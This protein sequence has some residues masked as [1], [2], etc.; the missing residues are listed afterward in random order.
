MAGGINLYAYVGQ[1]PINLIDP[2]G[3]KYAEQYATA[4]AIAGTGIVAAGSVVVDV[5][6][7][8]LNILATPAELAGGA[9]LGGAIGY[10][11]GSVVDWWMGEDS[12]DSCSS[13]GFEST[14]GVPDP[15]DRD[16]LQDK[17]LSKSEIRRL[18]KAGYDVHDLKG[19]KGASRY[20]LFK[21]RQ[22]NIYVK[23]KSGAGPGDSL[24]INIKNF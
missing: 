14:P 23:P 4:G 22:G 3:L 16:P 21:D 11:I 5:A 2:Y 13:S 24:G 17:K 15:D 12:G 8:G 10:G 9:A 19:G 7:G 20:D 6:T 1:N 18:K